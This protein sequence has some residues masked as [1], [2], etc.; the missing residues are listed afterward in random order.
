MTDHGAAIAAQH[1]LTRSDEWPD[2]ERLFLYNNPRCAGCDRPLWIDSLTIGGV[3]LQVHHRYAF[4]E[5]ILAGRPDLELDPR[6]LC[7]LCEDRPGLLSRNCHLVLGHLNSFRSWNP[8]LDEDLA[9]W[10]DAPNED[11]IRS[12]TVWLAKVYARPLPWPDWTIPRRIAFRAT[13][14][15]VFIPDPAI[16]YQYSLQLGQVPS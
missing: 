1:G 13:L 7:C 15:Q 6:N 9:H 5:C 12:D 4:H 2:V 11:A 16:L 8:T 10:H 3:G 14:D